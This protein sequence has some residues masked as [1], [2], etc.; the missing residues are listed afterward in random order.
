MNW[1]SKLFAKKPPEITPIK[2]APKR[3]TA[4]QI[5]NTA[6][7]DYVERLE[8]EGKRTGDREMLSRAAR[9]RR[10]LSP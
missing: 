3:V 1:L 8:A 2:P 5:A 6:V 7:V 10:K 4:A 9:I